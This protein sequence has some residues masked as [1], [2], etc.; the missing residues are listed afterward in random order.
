MSLKI[1]IKMRDVCMKTTEDVFNQAEELIENSKT[2]NKFDENIFALRDTILEKVKRVEDLSL[3][4]VNLFDEDS[5]FLAE[6]NL[7]TKFSIFTKQKLLLI[8]RYVEQHSSKHKSSDSEKEVNVPRLTQSFKDINLPK[9]E[10]KPF[11]GQ[12]DLW[13]EFYDNFE[14]TI[15]QNNSLS[16]VQKMSYLKSFLRGSALA[17]ISNFKLTNENYNTALDLLKERF[18]NKQLQI[19]IH[20]KNLLKIPTVSDLKDISQLRLVYDNIETQIRSL[21]NLNIAPE[22]YGPLLIPVLQSKLPSDLNLII[23]RRFNNLDCWDITEVLKVFKEELSAREKA[24]VSDSDVD[25]FTSSSLLSGNN[26]F[27]RS[28]ETLLC[29]FCNKNHKS[30]NCKIVTHVETRKNILKDKRRCFVCLKG[31]HISKQCTT[32]IE[33][34]KCSKRHHVALCEF[35]NENKKDDK[36]TPKKDDNK[37]DTNVN[38]NSPS[39]SVLLETA[40]VTVENNN[41]KYRARVLFDNGSQS[42]YITPSLREKL[43]LKSINSRDV[44]MKIFNNQVVNEKLDIVRVCLKSADNQK[45]FI[46]CFVTDICQ[47]LSGQDISY[48][49]ENFKHLKDLKLADTNIH[50][51]NLPIDI[52]IGSNY[53]WT[54]FENEIIRGEKDEPVATK[55]KFGYVLSGPIPGSNSQSNSTLICHSLKCATEI[56]SNDNILHETFE[57]FWEIERLEAKTNN[58]IVYENFCEDVRFDTKEARYEVRFPFKDDHDLLPDNYLHCKHRLNNLTKKLS[59]NSDLLNTYNGI[60]KSQLES[61]MIE[62]VVE[63][64]SSVGQI[65]YLPHRPVI[66]PEKNTKVRMVY[67]ASSNTTGPSLNDCL[68][69]GPSLCESLFGVLLRFRINCVAFIADIE[70]AFLQIKLHPKD[71]DFVRFI[72]FKDLNNLNIDNIQTAEQAIY[73]LCRVLFG[74]CSSPF[75]LTG[76]FIHHANTFLSID[77]EFVHLFLK[78]LHVDDLCSGGESVDTSYQFYSKCKE[79]L[80]QAS[81]NLQRFESN[82]SELDY[83]V[84]GKSSDKRIT[85]ILGLKWDKSNDTFIFDLNELKTLIVTKPTKREFI[86]FFASIYDPLGLINPFVV[87]FKCLFQKLCVLKIGWDEFLPDEVLK[88]WSNIILD[89]DSCGVLV[90]D[91]WYGNLGNAK[92][93]ELHGFSDASMGAFGCCIY[94]RIICQDNS[95][96]SSLVTAKS[97]VSPIKPISIPKLELQ[98]VV[99]LAN[100]MTQVKTEFSSFVSISSIHCWTDSMI[101]LHWINGNGKK[102]DVFVRRRIDEVRKLV[103]VDCWYH[104]ES[105]LNPADLLSRG[106]LFSEIKN[107]ELWFKGP[108]P[109]LSGDVSYEKFSL[110]NL[111]FNESVTLLSTVNNSKKVFVHRDSV[112]LHFIDIEKFGSYRKLLRI[113]AYILRFIDNLKRSLK[114]ETLNLNKTVSVSEIN[115]AENLWIINIQ[116]NL[117][118]DKQYEQLKNDL[119]FIVVDKIIR[120]KGRI[121]NSTLSY[122]SKYPIFIP[123]CDFGKLLVI[124]FHEIVLHNGFKETLNE[125]RTKFWIPKARNFIRQIIRNCAKCQKYDSRCYDYPINQT[126]LPSSRVSSDPPFTFT[127]L[128]YAGPLYVR[129]IYEGNKS[130]KAWIFLFTCSSTRGICLELVPSCDAPACIRGLS[131]FFSRRGT[132]TSILSD[133]G[134]NFTADETQQFVKFKNVDWKFNPPASPWWGGVY[135]R[136]VRSV[137]RCLKKIL[138]KNTVTYEELQTILYEI[139]LVLNNRPLTFTYENPND[140][141]LTPNHLLFGRRL[142]TE[143]INNNNNNID[144]NSRYRHIQKLLEQF[145]KRWR[146]E[147]LTELREFHKVKRCKRFDQPC[148]IGDVVLIHEDNTSRM[149]FR[150][151]VIDSFKPSRDGY[152]RVA[153]VR[154]NINGKTLTITRPVNKLYPVEC[155]NNNEEV[156]ITFVDDRDVITNI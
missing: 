64:D 140:A 26:K 1:K 111:V 141:V 14:C 105:K 113:T 66:K 97:R 106:L 92:R 60:I 130:Y 112:D 88:I 156:P 73:R 22:T 51:E 135:E 133:N 90:V 153:N 50:N 67:D 131:R 84:N 151:G 100:L 65:H 114:K 49:K 54:F 13:S 40:R 8:H 29:L 45:F 56:R 69:P 7:T 16:N 10:I 53:K 116:K 79:R 154:Y 4:I 82:S 39:E 58:D 115:F 15:H 98:G 19:T 32:K 61:G 118:D 145:I 99:L 86:Q 144:I 2:E 21:E 12:S 42:S 146:N 120:C 127:S 134:S 119:G 123:K 102:Q 23:S 31:G 136:I 108:S 126:D 71:K 37:T 59:T 143:G 147:Y 149:N 124:H 103:G 68:Y 46:N 62:R 75:L 85:K 81:F 74:V 139:E 44:T 72:W 137:K 93:V 77:P 24:Y 34:Y 83:L 17:V 52:L 6:E 148:S 5:D 27:K 95:I 125:L 128:D 104:V 142:N 138:G 110:K 55:T 101:V 30:Q 36:N 132:P 43:K 63:S 38:F 155:S 150:L 96:I 33:C 41:L 11:D 18:D 20:M 80:S 76:T 57:K 48:A 89:L 9:L 91:R 152:K 117:F 107:N 47:P 25:R 35:N 129:N 28:S 109:L 87:L 94:I 70:K 121:G 78:S 122:N 3:E